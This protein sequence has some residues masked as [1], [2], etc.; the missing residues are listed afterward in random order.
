MESELTE[1]DSDLEHDFA[2]LADQARDTIE[3]FVHDRPHAALGLA[4]AL[5]FVIGGGL[6]PRRLV[7]IGFA[8]GGPV[9]TRQIAAQLARIANEAW[10]AP[11]A[12][13]AS[14]SPERPIE[15]RRPDEGKG[16][17]AEQA[18]VCTK[19]SA[20]ASCSPPAGKHAT[21][22]VPSSHGDRHRDEW[23]GADALD[24][25]VGPPSGSDPPS[26]DCA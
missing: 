21:E 16:I 1:G 6:T 5:G 15:S 11:R 12:E 3:Q 25:V 20:V 7:R 24:E 10:I 14:E 26:S 17:G 18:S 4:A 23:L 13:Q 8:A 2:V 9:F 22:Q 19:G